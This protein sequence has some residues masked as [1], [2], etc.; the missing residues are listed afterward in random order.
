MVSGKK[1][2]LPWPLD[3]CEIVWLKEM[4]LQRV[5]TVAER[6]M[7]VAHLVGHLASMHKVRSPVPCETRYN[8]MCQQSQ[9]QREGCRRI[10]NP[11]HPWI[12]KKF[13]TRLAFVRPCPKMEEGEEEEEGRM[14]EGGGEEKRGGGGRGQKS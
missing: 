6:A 3:C 5:L 9:H 12:H 10:R 8:G 11:N 4:R 14:R 1:K 7:D 2:N 13:K